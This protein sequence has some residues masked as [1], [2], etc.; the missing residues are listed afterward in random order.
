MGSRNQSRVTRLWSCLWQLERALALPL[1]LNTEVVRDQERHHSPGCP[2]RKKLTWR[3]SKARDLI[4]KDLISG[5]IPLNV[6][7]MEAREVYIQPPE[8]A[9]FEYH[10]FRDRLQLTTEIRSKKNKNDAT[11]AAVAL[12]LLCILF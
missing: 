2:Q 6:N 9:N 4:E 5:D 12:P 10:H 7:V 8:F 3:G 1:A 11:S